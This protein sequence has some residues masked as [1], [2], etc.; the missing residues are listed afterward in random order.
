MSLYVPVHP[1]Y[2]GES[3]PVRKHVGDTLYGGTLNKAGPMWARAQG[4][5][6]ATAVQGIVRLVEEAQSSKVSRTNVE[7]STLA[8]NSSQRSDS[9]Q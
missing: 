1:G 6:S 7:M 2:L 8:K 9:S 4:V 3:M 5:G